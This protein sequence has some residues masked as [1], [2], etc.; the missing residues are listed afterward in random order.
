MTFRGCPGER[1]RLW[2]DTFDLV[3][4]GTP[5]AF[6]IAGGPA[7]TIDAVQ[8]LTFDAG[9]GDTV[10]SVALAQ[11]PTPAPSALYYTGAANV[12]GL[13]GPRVTYEQRIVAAFAGTWQIDTTITATTTNPATIVTVHY[14]ALVDLLDLQ[15]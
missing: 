14:V 4:D 8:A 6:T 11:V 13:A 15:P 1:R 12:L 2:V 3:G 10:T 9:G 7:G 5:H